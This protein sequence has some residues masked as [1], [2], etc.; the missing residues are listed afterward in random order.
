MTN[1]TLQTNPPMPC[2]DQAPVID[3]VAT[4]QEGTAA[5]LAGPLSLP[6]IAEFGADHV[7]LRFQGLSHQDC[8]RFASGVHPAS[9]IETTHGP[10]REGSKWRLEITMSGGTS[11]PIDFTSVE[12][13]RAFPGQKHVTDPDLDTGFRELLRANIHALVEGGYASIQCPPGRATLEEIKN[14]VLAYPATLTYP[15]PEAYRDI[16]VYAIQGK[17]GQWALEMDL[18]T[19]EEG[20]SDLTLLMDVYLVNDRLVGYVDQVHVL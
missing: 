20:R 18:W 15:P 9:A 12:V 6:A 4:W 19:I 17:P 13:M 2:L 5:L 8:L 7:L 3:T 11:I 10:A 1:D 16:H 14:E